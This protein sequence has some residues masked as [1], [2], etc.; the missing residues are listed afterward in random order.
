LAGV[1]KF[2]G[3]NFTDYTMAQGLAFSRVDATAQTPDGTMWFGTIFGLS[4]FDGLSWK[5]YTTENGLPEN[6]ITSIAADQEGK[7]WLGLKNKGVAV[8]KVNQP[9]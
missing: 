6:W 4:S 7:V 2:D 9:D 1:S 8:L 3:S 5:T